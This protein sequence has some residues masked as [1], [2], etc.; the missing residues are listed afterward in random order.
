[1]VLNISLLISWTIQFIVL[2]GMNGSIVYE[3]DRPENMGLE[4]SLKASSSSILS[5]SFY[6]CRPF[7]ID[8]WHS[9][10]LTHC[11]IL[12]FSLQIS[13][14]FLASITSSIFNPSITSNQLT[15]EWVYCSQIL[16]KAKAQVDAVRPGVFAQRNHD[17]LLA[18]FAI[19]I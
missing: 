13:D 2:G 3:L 18:P 10:M 7:C 11:S 15:P 17:N 4:K 14:V 19:V 6:F 8:M 5:F 16:E 9:S 1:M 12:F